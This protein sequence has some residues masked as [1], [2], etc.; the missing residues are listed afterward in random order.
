MQKGHLCCSLGGWW[1]CQG[2]CALLCCSVRPIPRAAYCPLFSLLCHCYCVK[3]QAFVHYQTLIPNPLSLPLAFLTFPL[4]FTVMYTS[5]FYCGYYFSF[6]FLP[7]FFNVPLLTANQ[8]AG[9]AVDPAGRWVLWQG[10]RP[11]TGNKEMGVFCGQALPGLLSPHGQIP[12]L[13]GNSTRH[14]IRL[15]QG[16]ECTDRCQDRIL[17]LALLFSLFS[18]FSKNIV[19]FCL[20]KT[21]FKKYPSLLL[22]DFIWWWINTW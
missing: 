5:L 12:N 14:I 18:L 6:F 3:A 10:P 9:K 7:L 17:M 19:W 11:C 21:Y 15:Q 13:L 16:C 20:M 1:F 2:V 22:F 8:R 4:S